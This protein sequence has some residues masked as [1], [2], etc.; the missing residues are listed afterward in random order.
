V[1]FS[2]E[3]CGHGWP[4]FDLRDHGRSQKPSGHEWPLFDPSIMDDR[5]TYRPWMA[6]A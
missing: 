6:A 3:K 1:E 5:K 4:L 2:I